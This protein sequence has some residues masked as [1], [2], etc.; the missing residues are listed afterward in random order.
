M[1]QYVHQHQLIRE[2][3]QLSRFCNFVIKAQSCSSPGA[4]SEIKGLAAEA[5]EGLT[6]SDD[7]DM[8]LN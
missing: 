5:F 2:P 8:L 1:E 6:A 4:K 7:F 3:G